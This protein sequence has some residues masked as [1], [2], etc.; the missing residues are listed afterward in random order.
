[1]TS[2]SMLKA[3]ARDIQIGGFVGHSC[4]IFMSDIGIVIHLPLNTIP[5]V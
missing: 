4:V 5:A 2:F 1:M 3:A